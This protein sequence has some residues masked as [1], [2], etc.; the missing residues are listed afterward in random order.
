LQNLAQV[1]V[2][3]HAELQLLR[4]RGGFDRCK[5]ACVV[6]LFAIE[7]CSYISG[8]SHKAT[9]VGNHF[10]AIAFVVSDLSISCPANVAAAG[11]K[12]IYRSPFLLSS[13]GENMNLELCCLVASMVFQMV[14]KVTVQGIFLTFTIWLN[15][16]LKTF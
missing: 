10:V 15:R 1:N 12:K 8:S 7:K 11:S 16:S 9:K 3:L 5:V 6:N 2:I 13:A 14:W 4:S